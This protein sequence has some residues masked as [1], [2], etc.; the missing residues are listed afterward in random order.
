MVDIE[1]WKNH[2]LLIV[3]ILK[4]LTDIH[5]EINKIEMNFS[6]VKFYKQIMVRTVTRL[7]D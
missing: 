6:A 2:Y 1:D 5:K 4:V 7:A 3:L